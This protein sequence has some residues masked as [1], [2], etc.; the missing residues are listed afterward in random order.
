MVIGEKEILDFKC[1]GLVNWF[2]SFVSTQVFKEIRICIFIS[3]IKFYIFFIKNCKFHIKI[4]NF[5]NL[6]DII[7]S[8]RIV[9]CNLLY[10]Y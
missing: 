2:M 5:E 9:N 8:D 4:K 3:F 10:T 1:N 7:L 6:F